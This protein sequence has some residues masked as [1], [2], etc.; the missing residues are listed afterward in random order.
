MF[1]HTFGIALL[2]STLILSAPV[3][4]Q[5]PKEAKASKGAAATND[6]RQAAP[7]DQK[8]GTSLEAAVAAVNRAEDALK[9]AKQQGVSQARLAELELGLAERR[10]ARAVAERDAARMI[11]S[12]AQHRF[13]VEARLVVNANPPN[14][15]ELRRAALTMERCQAEVAAREVACR[16]A[17]IEM[18]MALLRVEETRE[19]K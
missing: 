9:R 7:P 6:G 11:A 10:L 19:R 16:I 5:G 17:G 15:I 4:N 13:A 18:Q 8:T 1:H 12:E 2:A 14:P 3:T